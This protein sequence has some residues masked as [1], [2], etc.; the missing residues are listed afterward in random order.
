M[1]SCQSPPLEDYPIPSDGQAVQM[2]IHYGDITV[3]S[4]L[5]FTYID[6]PE[7]VSISPLMGPEGGGWP[8]T[9]HFD[10]RLSDLSLGPSSSIRCRFDRHEVGVIQASLVGNVSVCTFP[11]LDTLT[12]RRL[13]SSIDLSLS[14]NGVDWSYVG[15]IQ[16]LPAISVSGITPNEG[17]IEG[18]QMVSVLTTG[19]VAASS[20]ASGGL[21]CEFDG[22][23][24]NATDIDDSTNATQGGLIVKC[25]TPAMSSSRSIF[26]RVVYCDAFRP[27]QET[28]EKM[29]SQGLDDTAFTGLKQY[30]Y[31]DGETSVS[32]LPTSGPAP[33]GTQ[34]SV[35]ASQVSMVRTHTCVDLTFHI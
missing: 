10:N 25:L 8:I 24:F 22:V 9:I 18:N 28:I 23:L 26:V 29:H 1:Y 32:F 33:G 11:V 4:V 13:N 27:L 19:A 17:P 31:L 20:V 7:V 30:H 14:L 2:L 3:A 35:R 5:H 34:I 6:L 15:V 21:C 12:V 16:V